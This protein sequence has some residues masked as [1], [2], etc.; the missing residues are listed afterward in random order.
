MTQQARV[1]VAKNGRLVIPAALRKAI[2]LADGGDALLRVRDGRLEIEPLPA[3][4]ERAKTM[5]SR[6]A[7]GRNLVDELL[8]ERRGEAERE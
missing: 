2:G 8:R 1:S 7:A 3:A 6:Y 5:V 4:V